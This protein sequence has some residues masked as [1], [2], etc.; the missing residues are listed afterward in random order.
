MSL[1]SKDSSSGIIFHPSLPNLCFLI[2]KLTESPVLSSL[3]GDASG[4]RTELVNV[5]IVTVTRETE[6]EDVSKGKN[7]KIT[8][9]LD[10][11]RDDLRLLRISLE[12]LL[13]LF[14]LVS[15]GGFE[16][17]GESAGTG[18]DGGLGVGDMGGDDDIG[19]NDDDGHDEEK[20]EDEDEERGER[21]AEEQEERESLCMLILAGLDLLLSIL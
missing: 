8:F 6:Q 20:N 16:R 18:R 13:Y 1:I 5:F 14:L 12:K 21:G 11:A 4:C 15:S 10:L 3:T 19:D 9:S 7:H 2:R 17:R